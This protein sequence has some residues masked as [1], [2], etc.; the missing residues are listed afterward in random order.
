MHKYA[1]ILVT[2]SKYFNEDDILEINSKKSYFNKKPALRIT[3]ASCLS[4]TT[5]STLFFFPSFQR[6]GSGH[7]RHGSAAKPLRKI[8][9]GIIKHLSFSG[10]VQTVDSYIC[11]FNISSLFLFKT[12]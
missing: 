4:C 5:L 2:Y 9:S 7:P 12:A 11:R 8:K 6:L 1:V 10:F 3:Y